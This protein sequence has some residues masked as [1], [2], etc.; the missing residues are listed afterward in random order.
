MELASWIQAISSVLLLI[1]TAIYVYF[2]KRLVEESSNAFVSLEEFSNPELMGCKL[3][4]V[5]YGPG[6]ALKVIV[7]V[8]MQNGNQI[9]RVE[10]VGPNVLISGREAFYEIKDLDYG[11]QM[12]TPIFISFET[13]TGKK[14]TYEWVNTV[15]G[16]SNEIR[17]IR[18]I[19]DKKLAKRSE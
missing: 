12:I 5:N 14:F 16:R 4:L 18:K 2:N 7:K 10:A 13:Q 11:I 15:W 3:K 9:T 1:T 6:H 17:L 8:E 19:N